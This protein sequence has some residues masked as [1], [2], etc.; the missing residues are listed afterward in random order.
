VRGF[1]AEM[2]A[3]IGV[4]EIQARLLEAVEAELKET[5]A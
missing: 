1:F 4:A 5:L 2:I 3:R